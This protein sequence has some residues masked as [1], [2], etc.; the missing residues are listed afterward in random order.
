MS[1]IKEK[2]SAYD[3]VKRYML[4]KGII[5]TCDCGRTFY[6]NSNWSNDNT[7]YAVIENE[8]SSIYSDKKIYREQ[9]KQLL[10]EAT[11][12]DFCPFCSSKIDCE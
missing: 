7:I 8:F 5:L 4:Q 10:L 1:S 2:L 11:V 6:K 9:V 12:I 3:D